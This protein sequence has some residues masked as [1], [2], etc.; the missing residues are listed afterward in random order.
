MTDSPKNTVQPGYQTRQ[1]LPE[2]RVLDTTETL[3]WL[4]EFMKSHTIAYQ[5]NMQQFTVKLACTHFKQA[6]TLMTLRAEI[7]EHDCG[8]P[9]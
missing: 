6:P 1:T 7:E 3:A 8:Q 4:E 9:K 5:K 2:G